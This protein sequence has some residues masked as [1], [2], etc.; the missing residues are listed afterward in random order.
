MSSCPNLTVRENLALNDSRR[1]RSLRYFVPHQH[2]F[3]TGIRSSTILSKKLDDPV[4]TLSG[5]QRQMLSLEMAMRSDRPLVILDEITAA[6]DTQ[7]RVEAIDAIATLQAQGKGIVCIFH[8][9]DISFR[10]YTELFLSSGQLS[11]V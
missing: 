8:D 7:T 2:N 6:L 4:N 10:H 3:Q 1:A 11:V 5:G 9:P